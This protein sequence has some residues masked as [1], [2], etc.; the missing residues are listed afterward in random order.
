M[1]VVIV[2]VMRSSP[3]HGDLTLI[4]HLRMRSGTRMVS[5]SLAIF[6]IPQALSEMK[7]SPC[8]FTVFVDLVTCEVQMR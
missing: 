2:T 7:H 6:M 1:Q 4:T 3:S 8:P 5:S